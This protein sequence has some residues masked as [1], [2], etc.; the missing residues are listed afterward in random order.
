MEAMY[1]QLKE[2]MR[3]EQFADAKGLL[4]TLGEAQPHLHWIPDTLGSIALREG[5]I[6]DAIRF[7]ERA[8]ALKPDDSGLHWNLSLI[9][10][11]G[12]R[13]ERGWKEFEWRFKFNPSLAR[14]FSQPQWTG[15]EIGG[16]T[17][18]L[19]AE[20]GH[21]DAIHF[22]RYVPQVVRTGA[23][24]ILECHAPVVSLLGRIEGIQATYPRE[25]CL[26]PFDVHCSLPSLAMVFD[27]RLDTI[28]SSVPYLAPLPQKVERWHENLG[29]GGPF[30]VGLCW[31]GSNL[32]A[33]HRS[34]TLATFAPLA[35]VRGVEFH[36]L[37][38]GEEAKQWPPA[39]MRLIDHAAE[40]TD[41][42]ETA[43][44][45]A[46][47]DL[48]ITVDTSIAHLAGALARPTWVIIPKTPDFRW[49]LDRTDSPWYPTMRL[50]RQSRAARDWDAV[51]CQIAVALRKV[52]S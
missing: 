17:I 10:L 8:V 34:R 42:D 6:D 52:A 3:L 41:F 18:L 47:L 48:V 37:Q 39:G 19:H 43:A 22:C 20:G 33:D 44:L 21:G 12:G 13:F 5:R 51:A 49:L 45:V 15:E 28:P 26:T 25:R 38:V 9:L 7:A 31:A 2:H 36:S 50:F 35:G 4:E 40:L 1:A 30:R 23:R 27:T 29:G 24:V 32:P 46:N 14:P 11:T 16:K